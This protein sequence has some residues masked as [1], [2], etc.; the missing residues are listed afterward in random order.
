M[1]CFIRGSVGQ[2]EA[3]VL[4]RPLPIFSPHLMFLLILIMIVNIYR[5]QT[6]GQVLF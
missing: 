1:T 2:E 4:P 5:A 3:I 6:L